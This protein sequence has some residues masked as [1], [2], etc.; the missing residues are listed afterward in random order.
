VWGAGQEQVVQ[1]EQDPVAAED[2]AF[3]AALRGE[4]ARVRVPYEEAFVTHALV[5]AAD[6]AA[7]AAAGARA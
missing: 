1:S 3:V 6:G 7:R 2:Q 5:C 4:A